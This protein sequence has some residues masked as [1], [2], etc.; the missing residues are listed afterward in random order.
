MSDYEVRHGY[1]LAD[2]EGLAR[3]AATANRWHV[4]DFVIRYEAAWDAITEHLLTAEDRPEP[5]DLAR[6]GKGAVSRG[7]VKD[8]CH[9]YGYADRNLTAGIGSAPKFAA[10]WTRPP[11]T[12]MDEA[13]C[14]RVALPQVLAG[15]T[16][17]SRSVLLA[18]AATEDFELAAAA[19]GMPRKRL[20]SYLSL[21]RR[22][23]NALWFAP[24]PPPLQRR[25]P[26]RRVYRY[27]ESGLKPCGTHAAYG[28]HLS[29]DEPVDAACRSAATA[30]EQARRPRKARAA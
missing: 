19:L 1:T 11:H 22:E 7:L 28:R 13:V 30:Y 12:P 8:H 29:R 18:L 20:T 14:E 23:W 21:A 5:H 17:R 25:K 27:D 15:L 3:G 6:I 24:D 16:A 26:D 9:T 10:Y 2:L 4:S